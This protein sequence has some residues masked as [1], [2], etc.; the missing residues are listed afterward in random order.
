M[1]NLLNLLYRKLQLTHEGHYS[2]SSSKCIPS[3]Q[4]EG[5][6]HPQN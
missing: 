6:T 2:A 4:N 5:H 3:V 1:F